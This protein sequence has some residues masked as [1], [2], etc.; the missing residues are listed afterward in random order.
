[1]TSLPLAVPPT[2]VTP[3]NHEALIIITAAGGSSF[4]LL[5]LFIRGYIR[6]A[7]NGPWGLD[8]STLVLATV[9][10]PFSLE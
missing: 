8:D 1:M 10:K 4:A 3:E 7:F 6:V 9:I 2:V 5:S